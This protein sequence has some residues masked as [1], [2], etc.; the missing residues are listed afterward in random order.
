LRARGA[1]TKVRRLVTLRPQQKQFLRSLAHSLEPVVQV[2][3][4]G[5]TDNVL[6]QVRDQ[7][8]AHELI[9]VKFLK[10]SPIEPAEA[11]AAV[12]QETNSQVVQRLGR[13]LIVYRRH[14][15]KPKIV[16]PQ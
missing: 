9:K 13:L 6:V 14:D 11:V 10:E 8:R 3:K 16:F 1:A 15:Q 12:E 7:L 2:G 4:N 5:L